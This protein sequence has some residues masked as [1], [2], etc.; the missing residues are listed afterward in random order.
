MKKC[1]TSL[2]IKET[3]IKRTCRLYSLQSEWLSSKTWT[4]NV[5]ENVWKKLNYNSITKETAENTQHLEN[6]QHGPPWSVGHQRNKGGNQKD[7]RI[8]K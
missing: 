7:P 6:E 8:L 3:Q 5:G 4:T 2:V 1:S